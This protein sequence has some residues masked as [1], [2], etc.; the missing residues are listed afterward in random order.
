VLVSISIILILLAI[1]IEGWRSFSVASGAD[2]AARQVLQALNESYARTLSADGDTHYGVHFSSTSAVV[3]PGDTY[4]AG[5]Q[6]NTEYALRWAE[7]TNIALTG[8]VTEVLFTRLRGTASAW[9]T[10]TI[11]QTRDTTITRTVTIHASGLAE[12]Q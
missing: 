10:I 2:T 12:V 1:S 6:D 8:G 7:I 11:T 5:S 3:F 9:G 4:V